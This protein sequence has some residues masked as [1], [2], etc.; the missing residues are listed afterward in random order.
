MVILIFKRNVHP[1]DQCYPWSS[2]SK[3]K[4]AKSRKDD[5]QPR[6]KYTVR[7]FRILVPVAPPPFS[8]SSSLLLFTLLTTNN[9]PRT[10]RFWKIYDPSQ[11]S[12]EGSF[13]HLFHSIFPAN[14]NFSSR[15]CAYLFVIN[16]LDPRK[17]VGMNTQPRRTRCARGTGNSRENSIVWIIAHHQLSVRITANRYLLW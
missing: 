8:L 1:K 10:Q 9:F 5:V 4:Q 12:S 14:S 13:L 11:S 3:F 2:I 7:S 16:H 17:Q 6:P 15:N